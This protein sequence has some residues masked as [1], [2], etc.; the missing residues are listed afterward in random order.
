MKKVILTNS[1]AVIKGESMTHIRPNRMLRLPQVLELY[2]VSRSTWYAG[3][4]SCEFPASKR[5][6]KGTVGWSE[7]EIIKLAQSL[8]KN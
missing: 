1:H 7:D 4:K 3:V 6:S 5:L 8:S 2:P